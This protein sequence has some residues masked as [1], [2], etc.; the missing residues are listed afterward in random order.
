M[1]L[2]QLPESGGDL[3]SVTDVIEIQKNTLQAIRE[4]SDS[5]L[6]FASALLEKLPMLD[7]NDRAQVNVMA[8]TL[9][10]LGTITTVTTLATLTS[11]TNLVNLNNF[12]GGNTALLPYQF[13]AGAFHLYNN[14]AVS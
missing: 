8:G 4:L 11:A 5:M 7:Q 3:S 9:T 12:A 14:I 10:T 6:Y 2:T 1:P 13:G